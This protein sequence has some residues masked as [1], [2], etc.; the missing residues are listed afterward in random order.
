MARDGFRL[1]PPPSWSKL[2]LLMWLVTTPTWVV[3]A[4]VFPI[5]EEDGWVAAVA[6]LVLFL[7]P[8]IISIGDKNDRFPPLTHTIRHF[9]PNDFAF[10]LI[11]GAL[12]AIGGRWFGFTLWR[13]L[14]LGAMFAILGWL[15][16]H[17][18][19]S[20]TRPNPHPG[21]PGTREGSSPEEP[22]RAVP[23]VQRKF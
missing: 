4:F 12:G 8:E 23:Q 9:L 22:V 1:R 18:T 10:P 21:P 17:F 7:T 5:S 11:Y 16:I 6:F 19:L 14:G 13:Y 20:Y 2:W 3:L 15:T